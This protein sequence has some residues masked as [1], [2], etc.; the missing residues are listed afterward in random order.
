MRMCVCIDCSDMIGLICFSI[1]LNNF[2]FIS[3]SRGPRSKKIIQ[4]SQIDISP[5]SLLA[6]TYGDDLSTL[7]ASDLLKAITLSLVLLFAFC[8][9]Y[10]HK[11]VI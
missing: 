2:S 1:L 6:S 9:L 10:K 11:N 8:I 3:G 5:Q 4:N 7:T